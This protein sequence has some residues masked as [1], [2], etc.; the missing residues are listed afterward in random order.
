MRQRA[1][2]RNSAIKWSRGGFMFLEKGRG[3]R[4]RRKKETK[5]A[6]RGRKKKE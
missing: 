5:A 4:R 6:M 1:G 3:R 2:E